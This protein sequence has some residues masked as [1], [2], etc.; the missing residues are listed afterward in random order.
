MKIRRE[1]SAETAARFRS[2]F[3]R[4]SGKL[5]ADPVRRRQLG[6]V[7]AACKAARRPVPQWVRVLLF[8]RQTKR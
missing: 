3:E 1:T 8:A 7:L 5:A 2:M 6:A 4:R